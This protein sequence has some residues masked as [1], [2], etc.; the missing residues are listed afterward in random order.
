[1][2]PDYVLKRFVIFLIIVWA[3][4]TL[5]FFIPRLGSRSPIED[6]LMTQAATGGYLQQGVQEMVKE[7]EAK[8]G[9]DRPLW[10]QYLTYLSDVMHFDFNYSIANYPRRV[11]DILLEGLPWT[12]GLLTT[13]TVIAFTVG[14]LLGAFLGWPRAPKWLHFLMPPLLA[15][16]ALP[17]FLLGLILVYIFAFTFQILPLYGGFTAGT[18]PDWS[19]PSIVDVIQH[20][21]LPATSIV[22]V[23][24][25]GWALGMRAMMVTTQ[26]E[27]YSNF[28][29]AKGLK[30]RS[31]FFNYAIRNALLPQATALA[32]VL[33]QI[34]SGAVLVEVIFGYPG[35]GTVLFQAI[36]GS[37]FFLVQGIVFVVIIS[38]GLATFVL[39][40][41]YPLLDPRITYQRG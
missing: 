38:I 9:L 2:R 28:A 3:A 15:L 23:S 8:F 31:I 40:L 24:I 37:D 19:L 20:A 25:G 11:T 36:R 27:D 41:V 13:T 16:H 21:I 18:V 1:M 5:N 30:P 39:D 32:L 10:Q 4:A 34:L 12:I 7:Y 33:G 35:I 17:F 6:K 14:N 22:L 26:G 29:D